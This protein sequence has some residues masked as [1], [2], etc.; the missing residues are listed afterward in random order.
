MTSKRLVLPVALSLAVGMAFAASSATAQSGSPGTSVAH[1]AGG[2]AG[3]PLY[4]ALV[5]VRLVRAQQLLSDAA[6]D[7]DLGQAD[8][9]TQEL[10]AAKSNMRKAWAATKFLIKNA[11]PPVASA[12]SVK[13]G[14]AKARTSGGALPGASPYADV[15]TTA[16]GVFTL[17]DAVA[18]TALG[19]MDNASGALL[20]AVSSG[21]FAALNDRDTAIAYIH[22]IEPPPVA[23]DGRVKV[24]ASGGAI[25]GSWATTMPGVVPQVDDELQ[26]VDG[27]RG[28]VTLSPGRKKVLDDVELQDTKTEKTLNKYWP[29]IPAG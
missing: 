22:S 5:N 29:P 12:G 18:T 8:K 11:P 15:Y 10:N 20:T 13:H 26:Q 3:P 24:R 27:I 19:M 17:Q 6:E 7:A 23:G 21:V 25:A 2:S 28:T 16:L 9:A 4:P 1:A 14:T